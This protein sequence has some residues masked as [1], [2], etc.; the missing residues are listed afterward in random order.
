MDYAKN[1]PF[2]R[3]LHLQLPNI[4]PT[5]RVIWLIDTAAPSPC[6]PRKNG[7]TAEYDRRRGS[8]D[9]EEGSVDGILFT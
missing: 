1:G 5:N 2:H 7:L 8:H 3:S 4:G 9:A 6:G